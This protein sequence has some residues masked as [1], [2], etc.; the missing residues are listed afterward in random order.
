MK[1]F[2]VYKQSFYFKDIS[3]TESKVNDFVV[4]PYYKTVL[5]VISLN[6]SVDY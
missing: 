1:G 6:N 5:I 3:Y 2:G 4:M